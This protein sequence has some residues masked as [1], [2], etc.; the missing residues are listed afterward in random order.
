MLEKAAGEAYRQASSSPARHLS[1]RSVCARTGDDF[2]LYRRP[3]KDVMNRNSF[4]ASFEL[5]VLGDVG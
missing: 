3:R 4:A 1:R 2:L 5:A